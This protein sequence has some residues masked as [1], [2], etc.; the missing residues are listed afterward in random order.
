M[1]GHIIP[2]SHR[3]VSHLLGAAHRLSLWQTF[4]TLLT[5][6]LDQ[7]E[8]HFWQ[9][10]K[11]SNHGDFSK[12]RDNWEK[13]ETTMSAM[14]YKN[15]LEKGMDILTGLNADSSET[16]AQAIIAWESW[17]HSH[18][19]PYIWEKADHLVKDY[20]GDYTIWVRKT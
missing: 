16:R 18:P 5:Q 12:A 1:L 15:A 2:E 4:D 17:Q 3:P 13:A 9:G 11:A 6:V 7:K 20:S 10:L 8:V 14:T 19:G